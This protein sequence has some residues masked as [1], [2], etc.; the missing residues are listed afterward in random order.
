MSAEDKPKGPGGRP[1]KC[2]PELLENAKYYLDNWEDLGDAF[3]HI[4][5]L[6]K[7]IDVDST[8]IYDWIKQPDKEEFSLIVRKLLDEQHRTLVNKGFIG[9]SSPVITKLLLS[10]HGYSDKQETQLSG[11]IEITRIEHVIVD[12]AN[13]NG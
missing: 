4:M 13:T 8:T 9:T 10:K 6:A 3:P 5:G 12:P 1:T 2:I 11:E 7:K